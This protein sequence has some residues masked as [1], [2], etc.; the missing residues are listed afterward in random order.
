M[1]ISL[2]KDQSPTGVF[3]FD[4]QE[5]NTDLLQFS[6]NE[7]ESKLRKSDTINFFYEDEEDDSDMDSDEWEDNESEGSEEKETIEKNGTTDGKVIKK[8]DHE[9]RL[10]GQITPRS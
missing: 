2:D 10:P 3:F 7:G 9:I 8:L 6:E 5:Q 1:C 4:D